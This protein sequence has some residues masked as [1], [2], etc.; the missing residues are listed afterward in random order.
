MACVM[1]IRLKELKPII[2]C[3]FPINVYVKLR[4]L[5]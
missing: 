1:R 3:S 4:V 2:S 5:R